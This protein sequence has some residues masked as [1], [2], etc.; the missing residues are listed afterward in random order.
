MQLADYLEFESIQTKH[1]LA[2]KIRIKGHRIAIENVI[3]LFNRGSSPERIVQEFYPS[4]T[5]AEVYATVAYYLQ[6]K[7]EVDAYM[8]RGES[9]ADAFYQEWLQQEPAPVVKRLRELKAKQPPEQS[10]G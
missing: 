7:A 4:L 6:N 8:Q 5:L 10:N 2:E 9:I 3:E 1:G